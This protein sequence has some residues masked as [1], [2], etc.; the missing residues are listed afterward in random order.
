VSSAADVIDWA[1]GRSAAVVGA[2]ESGDVSVD[3]YDFTGP[4][5]LV[6][7]N[8]ATRMSVA[9]RAA[10]WVHSSRRNRPG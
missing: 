5:L 6:I 9:R 7:G 3:R 1:R 10:A 2:D 8:E 4:T